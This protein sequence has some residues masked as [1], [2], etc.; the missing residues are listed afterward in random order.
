MAMICPECQHKNIDGVVYCEKCGH[1]FGSE[2]EI[3]IAPVEKTGTPIQQP[4][5]SPEVPVKHAELV[6]PAMGITKAR[7]VPKSK[8]FPV[9]EILLEESLIVIGK[10]DP[11]HGPVDFDLEKLIG[12]KEAEKISRQHAE[13]YFESGSWKI[14]DLDSSNGVFIKRAGERRFL[15]K[16]TSPEMLHSGDEIAIA[17]I[18]FVFETL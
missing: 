8:T 10:F 9:N 13:V 2:P 4:I 16:I 14:K 11:D 6:Q 7:L 15:P 18:G 5:T 12:I 1:E 17:D 3:P